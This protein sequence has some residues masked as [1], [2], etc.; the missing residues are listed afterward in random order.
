MRQNRS[1]YNVDVS[2]KGK[3]KRTYKG[4]VFDSETELK[5][6]REWIEPKMK[7]GEIV[8]YK[9]QV[10]YILQEGFTNFEGKKILPVKYIADYVIT[11]KNGRQIV[12][13]VKGQPDA[14]AK[15]KKKLF[16]YKYQDI[17]F[18]WYC[19]T[20][21]YSSGD[22]WITYEELEKQRKANKKH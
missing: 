6:L 19:R 9:M 2:N 18:Y 7:I 15:L 5:F 16:E 3:A 10:P 14:T 12:V 22:N 4:V 20:V 8:S 1:K 11:F 21:K 13:D 17:P